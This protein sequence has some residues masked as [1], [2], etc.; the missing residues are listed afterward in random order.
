M[1]IIVQI[2]QYYR[3]KFQW[4][5]VCGFHSFKVDCKVSPLK[6]TNGSNPL[7]PIK[8]VYIVD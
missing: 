4:V 8:L 6:F 5:K 1:N 2:D 7:A 3:D